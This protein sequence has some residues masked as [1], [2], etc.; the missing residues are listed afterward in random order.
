MKLNTTTTH[1]HELFRNLLV[2]RFSTVLR[3]LFHRD[4]N[5][6]RDLLVGSSSR[7][8]RS[9]HQM[10][11][12]TFPTPVMVKACQKQ[13]SFTFCLEKITRTIETFF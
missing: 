9:I 11:S 2:D 4:G 6:D 5:G 3:R 7:N 12:D 10:S 13:V 8:L 1:L